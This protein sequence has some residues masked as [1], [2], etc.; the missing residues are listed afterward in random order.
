MS[1]K[2]PH[3]GAIRGLIAELAEGWKKQRSPSL[4][5]AVYTQL[6]ET[7]YNARVPV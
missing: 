3:H 4:K 7:H 1:A 5:L 6:K 2:P